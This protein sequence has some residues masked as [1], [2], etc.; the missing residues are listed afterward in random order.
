MQSQC[1][2]VPLK[3]GATQQFVD[4]LGSVRHREAEMLHAMQQEGVHFELMALQRGET[5]DTLL[6]FMQARDL[7]AAQ[8]AFASSQ[9]PIDVETRN[10][11]ESC[12]DT[13]RASVLEVLLTL[14]P[15]DA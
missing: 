9:L 15:V 8:N 5:E 2:R 14:G 4:W 6:F 11:I 3:P 13:A 10:V 7:A 12:W 1:V